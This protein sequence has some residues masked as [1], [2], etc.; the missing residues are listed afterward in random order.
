[1]K[2]EDLTQYLLWTSLTEVGKDVRGAIAALKR[3]SF[4]S[5]QRRAM[6]LGVRQYFIIWPLLVFPLH[7]EP[8]CRNCKLQRVVYLSSINKIGARMIRGM[9]MI[10][11]CV[12]SAENDRN[13]T[14]LFPD[15]ADSLLNT[16][17]PVCH[18]RGHHNKI[19]RT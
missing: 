13:I 6:G 1:M 17:I 11:C 16:R 8:E 19:N 9:L 14:K 5:Q 7:L 3:A 15:N 12:Y 4:R 10:E 18:H 2:V